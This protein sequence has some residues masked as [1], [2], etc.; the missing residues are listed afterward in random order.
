SNQRQSQGSVD[1]STRGLDEETYWFSVV[2][3]PEYTAGVLLLK[4][5]AADGD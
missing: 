3:A 5:T 2:V 1:H 4:L